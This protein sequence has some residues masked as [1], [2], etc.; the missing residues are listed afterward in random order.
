[1]NDT[2]VPQVNN[3]CPD[4]WPIIEAIAADVTANQWFRLKGR[5]IVLRL[6]QHKGGSN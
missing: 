6:G 5:D 4:Q 1:M 3:D 2:A